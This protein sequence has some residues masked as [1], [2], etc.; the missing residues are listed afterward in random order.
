MCAQTDTKGNRRCWS[1]PSGDSFQL[2]GAPFLILQ[3]NPALTVPPCPILCPPKTPNGNTS[4]PQGPS[5]SLPLPICQLYPCCTMTWS[6]QAVFRLGVPACACRACCALP[7]SVEP[8]EPAVPAVPAMPAMPAL[9]A[10]PADA[11]LVSACLGACLLQSHASD[12]SCVF[13]ADP[14]GVWQVDEA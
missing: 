14:G 7:W 4:H 11:C 8:A 12:G 1:L 6:V 10:M 3:T 2:P 9:P 5:P 13:S